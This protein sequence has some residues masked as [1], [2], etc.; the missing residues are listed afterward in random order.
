MYFFGKA[1]GLRPLGPSWTSER[2]SR[3]LRELLD[4]HLETE[5]A[6]PLK[7]HQHGDSMFGLA[8]HDNISGGTGHGKEEKKKSRT[9]LMRKSYSF[10]TLII[11]GHRPGS[12]LAS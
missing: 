9:I 8:I 11:S 7:K 5:N 4:N 10:R 1:R 2:I 6:E 12:T 3:I